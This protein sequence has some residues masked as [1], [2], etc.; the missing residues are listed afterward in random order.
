MFIAFLDNFHGW[1]TRECLNRQ[2]DEATQF[3]SESLSENR[4]LVEDHVAKV[5]EA[6]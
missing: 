2:I 4:P 5:K 6:G 3:T 1:K